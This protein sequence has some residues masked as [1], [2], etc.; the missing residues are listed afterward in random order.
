MGHFHHLIWDQV[1]EMFPHPET[2]SKKR[3]VV[4]SKVIS[5]SK[6]QFNFKCEEFQ[7][8]PTGDAAQAPK[9]LQ[10]FNSFSL[11]LHAGYY[12]EHQKP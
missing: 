7:S 5:P 3:K 11:L 2:N 9:S 1:M 6:S 4:K 10:L 12:K 8:P